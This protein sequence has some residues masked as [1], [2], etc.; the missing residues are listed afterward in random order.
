M[1]VKRTTWTLLLLLLGAVV[2]TGAVPATDVPETSYNEIDRPIN[3]ATPNSQAGIRVVRPA[4]HDGD[5]PAPT[6]FVGE[7][8]RLEPA[9]GA[10]LRQTTDPHR[11]SRPLQDLLCILII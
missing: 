1:T 11:S 8:Q 6:R 5:I 4:D 3:Q 2:W 7:T 9:A 10:L